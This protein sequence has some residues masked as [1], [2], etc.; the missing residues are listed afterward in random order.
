MWNQ[1]RLMLATRNQITKQAY[2]DA[3]ANKADESDKCANDNP[4]CV[5]TLLTL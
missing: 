1:N 2:L 4:A 3:Q 5:F